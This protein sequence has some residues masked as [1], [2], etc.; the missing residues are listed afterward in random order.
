MILFIRTV[1]TRATVQRGVFCETLDRL[2]VPGSSWT[3]RARLTPR[4]DLH[5]GPSLFGQMTE[6]GRALSRYV[7][8]VACAGTRMGVEEAWTGREEVTAMT[9]VENRISF[10]STVG[11]LLS[12]SIS[13]AGVETLKCT[14]S[15]PA[16]LA[17][18][19]FFNSYNSVARCLSSS[20]P[21]YFSPRTLWRCAKGDTLL[22]WW[23]LRARMKHCIIT[24]KPRRWH[25]LV[26]SVAT[27]R[28]FG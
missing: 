15:P 19:E 6:S 28:R 11:H 16:S 7:R 8:L 27:L 2:F 3:Y 18:A 9:C 5:P 24:W 10:L 20:L 22:A 25:C 12:I 21:F 23:K 4:R 17:R 13:G 26:I 14:Q 1:H